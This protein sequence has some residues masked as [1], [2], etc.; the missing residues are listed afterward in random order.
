VI[1]REASQ[2]GRLLLFVEVSEGWECC[3]CAPAVRVPI[4]ANDPNGVAPA[5]PLIGPSVGWL[6][7]FEVLAGPLFSERAARPGTGWFKH[8]L[9]A[10]PARATFS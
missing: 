4:G 2:S 10:E 3:R 6:L 8:R 1:A 7:T 5:T 9:S